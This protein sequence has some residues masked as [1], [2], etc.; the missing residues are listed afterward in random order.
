[1]NRSKSAV[2]CLLLSAM[3]AAAPAVDG[4]WAK[5]G[6]SGSGGGNSGSGSGG[7]SG[8]GGG[9]NS[10]SGNAGQGSGGSSGSGGNNSGGSGSPGSGG[11]VV[12]SIGKAPDKKSESMR[13][14]TRI[15]NSN[16]GRLTIKKRVQTEKAPASIDELQA[17][18]DRA[19]KALQEAQLKF[20]RGLAD[21]KA[22][23]RML[24]Q[25]IRNAEIA[26]SAVGSKLVE[27]KP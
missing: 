5:D 7:N 21:P 14:T 2:L 15:R 19:R 23:L 16:S 17:Q 25:A 27:A 22:N 8:T 24:E 3:L 13:S 10:G 9:G 20:N 6:N 4:A 26:I 11:N 1:M 18:L 12:A